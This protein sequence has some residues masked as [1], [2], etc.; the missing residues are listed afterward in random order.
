MKWNHKAVWCT[1][2]RPMAI[3]IFI[4][5]FWRL[6]YISYITFP[7]HTSKNDNIQCH[8][9]SVFEIVSY[10]SKCRAKLGA[11]M[12]AGNVTMSEELAFT[13]FR[14]SLVY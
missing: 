9:N 12:L 13:N 10:F 4:C 8:K 7:F 6:C 1:S 3:L 11:L 14:K 5:K 2:M